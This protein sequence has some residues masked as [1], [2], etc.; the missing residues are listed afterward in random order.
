MEEKK[1]KGKD[2]R[3]KSGKQEKQA[4]EGFLGL[5]KKM[6]ENS[7]LISQRQIIITPNFITAC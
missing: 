4:Q 6:C 2:F 1:R 5:K 3:K 7:F